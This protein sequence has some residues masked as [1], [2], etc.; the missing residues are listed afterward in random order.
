[1]DVGFK[2]VCYTDQM[3]AIS[4]ERFVKLQHNVCKYGCISMYL[5][6]MYNIYA[7][8]GFAIMIIPS[9]YITFLFVAPCDKNSF[10][11]TTP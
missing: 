3:I 2:L 11:P 4:I 9:E 5:V 6:Y 1:M 8:L 7:L 10:H